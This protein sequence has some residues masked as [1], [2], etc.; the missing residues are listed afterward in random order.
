MNT[1]KY[2]LR[3][4]RE[5]DYKDIFEIVKNENVIKNLNMTKHK[6]EEETKALIKEYL[7]GLKTKTKY[8]FAIIEKKSQ[9][10]LGVFLIK[11]DL[12]DEDSFEF[13]IYINE[14]Y[15][16]Q[17]IYK[18]IFPIMIDFTFTHIKTK[19][20]RGF[21]KEYN[22]ASSKVLENNHFKLEKIFKVPNIPCNIK[23]YVLTKKEYEKR[24]RLYK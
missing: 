1:E 3:Y 22:T 12:Y 16:Y 13:T 21:V 10:F 23:S 2:H 6:I 4:I 11:L 14:K 18:E 19:N 24:K 9:N 20:F 8:P 5:E 15:W 7:N 17:G